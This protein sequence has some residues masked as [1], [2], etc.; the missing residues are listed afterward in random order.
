[1]KKFLK[2]SFPSIIGVLIGVLI[3]TPL[4]LAN[5][6]A[7][8]NLTWFQKLVKM[9]NLIYE[10]IG[11]I[12]AMLLIVGSIFYFVIMQ[13]RERKEEIRNLKKDIYRDID[14]IILLHKLIYSKYAERIDFLYK[15]TKN[16]YPQKSLFTKDEMKL[17]DKIIE[18]QPDLFKEL[19][20]KLKDEPSRDN[21]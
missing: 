5:E 2:T 17:F 14:N 8:E 13:N 19:N 20:P 6:K 15:K 3:I 12:T 10:H 7:I 1:M 18:L 9:F 11:I 4:S 21:E 16:I